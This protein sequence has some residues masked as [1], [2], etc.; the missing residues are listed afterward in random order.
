MRVLSLEGD[1]NIRKLP[2]DIT[3][4]L[5]LGSPN[6]KI[7]FLMG[8]TPRRIRDKLAGMVQLELKFRVYGR[9]LLR[10]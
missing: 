8:T 3:S 6:S 4:W 10:S 1:E 2:T 7:E 9:S 5:Y